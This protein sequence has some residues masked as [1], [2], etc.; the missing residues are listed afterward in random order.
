MSEAA[1]QILDQ[2]EYE[3]GECIDDEPIR[4]CP[5]MKGLLPISLPIL[6]AG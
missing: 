6:V 2:S 4:A 1:Q 5:A 3:E